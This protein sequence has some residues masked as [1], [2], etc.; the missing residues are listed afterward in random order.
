[1]KEYAVRTHDEKVC[2]NDIFAAVAVLMNSK[3]SN[4]DTNTHRDGECREHIK[5]M[6]RECQSIDSLV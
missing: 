3:R 5:C 6:I 4:L 2:L 1:M